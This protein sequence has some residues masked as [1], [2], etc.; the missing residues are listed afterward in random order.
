MGKRVYLCDVNITTALLPLKLRQAIDFPIQTNYVCNGFGHWLTLAPEILAFANK[1]L[2][3]LLEYVVDYTTDLF[4]AC[5]SHSR[6]FG[7]NPTAI[8]RLTRNETNSFECIVRTQNVN[9]ESFSLKKLRRKQVRKY[10]SSS[11]D[12]APMSRFVVNC[13]YFVVF[14]QFR[15]VCVIFFQLR[16]DVIR[17]HTTLCIFSVNKQLDGA[18]RSVDSVLGEALNWCASCGLR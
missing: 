9:N 10:S 14:M 18:L 15:F 5:Y 1:C 4:F 7:L 2:T 6:I 8:A 13:M 16:Y 17:V 12:W 3:D 11:K